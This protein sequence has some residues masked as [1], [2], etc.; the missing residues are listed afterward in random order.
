MNTQQTIATAISNT[1]AFIGK[2]KG[3]EV[4]DLYMAVFPDTMMA[5]GYAE[6]GALQ[7]TENPYELHLA[8]HI[9]TIVRNGRNEHP[10]VMTHGEFLAKCIA[11]Q[12]EHLI[13]LRELEKVN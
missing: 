1:E 9:A 7:F 8:S 12:E 10:V 3:T 4:K 2:C 13:V 11:Q 6:G 5:V